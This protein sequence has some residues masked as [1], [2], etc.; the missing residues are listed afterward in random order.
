MTWPQIQQ[1]H[2]DDNPAAGEVLSLYNV[3]AIPRS[4]VIERNGILFAMD[5]R[6]KVLEETVRE[7]EVG[8]R[9]EQ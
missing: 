2:D 8:K 5:V 6:G 1:F 3:Y 9:E 7:L 4:F